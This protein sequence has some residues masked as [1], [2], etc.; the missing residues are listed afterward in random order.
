MEMDVAADIRAPDLETLNLYC[1]RV[2]VAV[3][4]LSIRIFGME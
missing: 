4:R 1:D 2:A 3:G